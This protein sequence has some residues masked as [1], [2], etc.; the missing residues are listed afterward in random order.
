M[1]KLTDLKIKSAIKLAGVYGDGAGL[2]LRVKGSGAASWVLRVQFQ[3][4]RRDIG[5]GGYPADRSLSEAR[6]DAARLRKLARRGG[7]A[8]AER[9]KVRVQIP[10]FSEAVTSAHEEFA[11]G[12]SAK[13]AASFK[14]SLEQHAVPKMGSHRVDHIGTEQIVATLAPI[15]TVKPEIAKKVRVRIVQVLDFARSNGW[16]ADPVPTAKEITRGLA[17]QPRGG[18]FEAMPFADVPAFAAAQLAK[19]RSSARLALLFAILTA[20][21]SGEV[22][23][24]KWEHID[25]DA[26]T[27]IRPAELMKMREKHVVTLNAAA[28][29]ILRE[30]GALTDRTGLIFPGIKPNTTLS[31]M[32]LS[33]QMKAAGKTATVH[34]FRSSFRDW[35]AERMASVPAMVA[36]MALAHKV[37]A[38][39]E[40]AYLRS[41]L[42]DMRRALMDAWGIFVAPSLSGEQSNLT[43]IFTAADSTL[44]A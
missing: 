9:D 13:N 29:A 1:G 26:R 34:G 3:G 6:E 2:Y 35:A 5:L 33:K 41:D 37:G 40:Q 14:S 16:R 31:D 18:N 19:G 11:K 38:K 30:A 32:T 22:R 4:R 10:T 12:W 24:S 25:L 17:R 27:W 20:A 42:R 23:S 8:I 28:L 44:I 43:Q 15:W 36:E 7:N 39:T 21:R